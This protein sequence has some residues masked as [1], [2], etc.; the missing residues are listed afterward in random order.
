MLA[1]ITTFCGLL[2]MGA[3]G[4]AVMTQTVA[5]LRKLGKAALVKKAQEQVKSN[6]LGLPDRA[7]APEG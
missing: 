7:E 3:T 6:I 1:L 5:D 2:T 4:D